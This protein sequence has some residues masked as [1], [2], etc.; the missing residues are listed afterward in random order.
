MFEI[1]V[2]EKIKTR[3]ML[4]NVLSKIGPFMGYVKKYC[5]PGQA[6]DDKAHALFLLDN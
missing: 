5:R 6:T 4:N 3:Y 1:N 2:V